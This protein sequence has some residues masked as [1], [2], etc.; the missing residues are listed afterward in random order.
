[1]LLVVLAYALECTMSKMNLL[2]VANL[3]QEKTKV[4]YQSIVKQENQ[5]L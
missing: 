4:N 3:H 2:F 1:M 5:T